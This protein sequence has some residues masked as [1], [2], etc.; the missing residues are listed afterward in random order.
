MLCGSIRRNSRSAKV[1]VHGSHIDDLSVTL[2]KHDLTGQ[3]GKEPDGVHIDV[4]HRIP[5][6]TRELL[7]F[8]AAGDA[9]VV[10]QNIDV[11]VKRLHHFAKHAV[12]L[13]P[14]GQIRLKRQDT[15]SGLI[16]LPR[17]LLDGSGIIHQRDNRARVMQCFGN[18]ASHALRCAGDDSLAAFQAEIIHDI[19]FIHSIPHPFLSEKRFV[20][21]LP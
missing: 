17:G 14:L 16:H 9:R 2:L 4:N 11:T 8:V 6:L 7:R 12:N 19:L 21:Q 18:A 15:F 10:D 1:A 20:L 3:L 13:L 5:V